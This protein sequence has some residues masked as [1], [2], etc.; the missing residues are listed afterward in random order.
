M[1]IGHLFLWITY[2]HVP[3][4]SLSTLS[5]YL[6]QCTHVNRKLSLLDCNAATGAEYSQIIK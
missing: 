6:W 3:L 2:K 4:V 1:L 5:V